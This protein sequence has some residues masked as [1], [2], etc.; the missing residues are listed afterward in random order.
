MDLT[1][2][3]IDATADAVPRNNEPANALPANNL[4]AN[5]RLLVAI[6]FRL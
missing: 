5:S 4:P 3:I 1:G 2:T 6:S